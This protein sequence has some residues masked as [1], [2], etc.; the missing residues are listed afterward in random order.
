[1]EERKYPDIV[2]IIYLL[3]TLPLE[4]KREGKYIWEKDHAGLWGTSIDDMI[5]V[6]KGAAECYM[7]D[8]SHEL[9]S[10]PQD[11]FFYLKIQYST[12]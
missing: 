6:M 7:S 1:M 2:K 9:I 12:K 11:L 4:C 10:N 3:K 5:A 8:L